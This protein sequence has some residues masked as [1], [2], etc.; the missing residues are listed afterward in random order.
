M[1]PVSR[2]QS[3]TPEENRRVCDRVRAIR[4]RY[5][6]N[7]ALALGLK[8]PGGGGGSMSAFTVGEALRGHQMGITF[9]RAVAQHEGISFEELTSGMPPQGASALHH[10]DLPGW[11]EAAAAVVEQGYA[12]PYAV[13][14]A[15]DALVSFQPERVSLI[16]VYDQAVLWLKHASTRVRV[17]AERAA[18]AEALRAEDDLEDARLSVVGESGTVRE[19]DGAP[20]TPAKA[21]R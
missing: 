8:Q 4:K 20:R 11:A 5:K 2:A 1:G 6:T 19:S 9:A 7:A 15:A 10:R 18:R 13:A 14:G 3:L 16:Y 17:A 12:P 21:K